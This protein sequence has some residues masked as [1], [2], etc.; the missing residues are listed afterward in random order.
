MARIVRAV[1]GGT[2][3]LLAAG[4][5]TPYQPLGM[6]GG[7]GEEKLDE[8]T[9]RVSFTGNQNTPRVAVQKFFL[10]RCAELTLQKGYAYFELYAT[11]REPSASADEGPFVKV[12]GSRSSPPPVVTVTPTHAVVSY[13][14]KAIV[15][16]YPKD[17]LEENVASLFSAKEIVS[18]L[19]AEVRSGR[20]GPNLPA[21]FRRVE[22]KFPVMP[23]ERARA[24]EP[25]KPAT[26]PVHLDDLKGL[27]KQ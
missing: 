19:G 21:K 20:P 25:R 24:P 3:A 12:R 9:Y 16:M 4:C 8:D 18:M 5:M 22:G 23:V 10:H 15:R 13:G 14:L 11:E 26:G 2:L 1:I 17:L 27:M 6:T 7:W